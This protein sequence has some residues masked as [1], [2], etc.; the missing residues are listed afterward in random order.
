MKFYF[1]GRL[2]F[3]EFVTNLADEFSMLASQYTEKPYTRTQKMGEKVLL[4]INRI[5]FR[6]D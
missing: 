1:G 5:A 6:L 2:Y 3:S 4:K